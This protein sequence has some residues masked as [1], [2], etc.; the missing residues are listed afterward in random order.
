AARATA[1][2]TPG[3][4]ARRRGQ[5]GSRRAAGIGVLMPPTVRR[6][7]ASAR[8]ARSK[9]PAAAPASRRRRGGPYDA[10]VPRESPR[11]YDFLPGILPLLTEIG[12]VGRDGVARGWAERAEGIGCGRVSPARRRRR[13]ASGLLGRTGLAPVVTPG[14]GTSR[15]VGLGGCAAPD[16]AGWAREAG[17]LAAGRA[18]LAPPFIAAGRAGLGVAPGPGRL[19][20]GGVAPAAGRAGAGPR[21]ERGAPSGGRAGARAG[22][23]AAEPGTGPAPLGIG[24]ASVGRGAAA[25]PGAATLAAG[26]GPAARAGAPLES[27]AAE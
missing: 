7:S 9:A 16:D 22:L 17:P 3:P 11:R 20:A 1:T 10:A 12:S 26:A 19:D 14:G 25:R 27:V 15:P 18:G 13:S 2:A 8:P 24:R 4:L 5:R 21:A 23:R 6:E